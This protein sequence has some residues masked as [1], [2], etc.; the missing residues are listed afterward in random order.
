MTFAGE[1]F[2]GV[3]EESDVIVVGGGSAGCAMASRLADAGFSVLLVEAGKSDR[4][5]RLM[6]PALT[7][8][9]VHNP[10]FDW[11]FPAEPDPSIGGRADK[12]PAGKRL[13]GGSAINGMIYVRGH[14]WDYDRWAELG[15]TGWSADDVLPYFAQ[16]ETSDRSGRGRGNCGPISVVANR[17]HYP[18]VDAFIDGA[19]SYGV[20]R[21]PDHNG[22]LSGEGT[23]YS[24]T[25]QR[26]GMRC[27]SARGYLRSGPQR[28][29]LA[30]MT[31]ALV[32]R[33]V[34]HD[35]RAT[36]IEVDHGGTTRTLKARNGVV[37]CAGSMNSPRLLMLSGIG[38]ADHLREHGLPVVADLPGVGA[39]LQEHVGTHIVARVRGATV[40]S[41][42]RGLAAL[43]EGL[44]YVLQRSGAVSSSMCHAQAFVHSGPGLPVPDLQ[45]SFT[46]FAFDINDVGRAVLRKEPSISLTICLAR[47]G[48]RGRISLRSADPSEP[49]VIQ[50]QLLG[51]PADI[52]KLSRGVEI[53]REILNQ[54]AIAPYIIEELRPGPAVQAADLPEYLRAAS[55]P[56]YHPAGTCRM[57]QDSDAVVDPDLKVHGVDGLWVA[58]A[59]VMPTLPIG[60]TNATAIMIGDK[61]ADHVLKSLRRNAAARGQVIA[62]G[63][64]S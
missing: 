12:W 25:T 26:G 45:I 10:E 54:P 18:I 24:Q 35:G 60:N 43:R 4:D 15:A 62:A 47:P 53:G 56:L 14:R 9:A 39:N 22:A 38:P 42:S 27:S 59:S 28:S 55:I 51:D 34:I 1:A 29:N 48:S 58:D 61:G 16:M 36:G 57:G 17:V 40:N 7:I 63:A 33:I 37:L 21:N 23:D 2:P 5:L 46:A 52:E 50:H 32:R 19:V 11:G 41:D 44:K 30:V 31:E 20:P 3:S 49:P 64:N 6:V 13:G 8:A